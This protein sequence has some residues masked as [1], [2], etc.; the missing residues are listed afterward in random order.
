MSRLAPTVPKIVSAPTRLWSTGS[1]RMFSPKK[2]K[3]TD[4][5]FQTCA[6]VKLLNSSLHDRK[7]ARKSKK[8]KASLT[9][10]TRPFGRDGASSR[11]RTED[12]R[13]TKP[14]LY[15]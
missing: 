7:S 9:A 6:N 15:H 8:L 13:F 2:F 5:L 1:V 4:S 12:R 14:L 10:W 3:R 11:I